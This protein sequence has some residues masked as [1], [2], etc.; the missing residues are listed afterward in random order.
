MSLF[1][2]GRDRGGGEQVLSRIRQPLKVVGMDSDHLFPL[3]QQEQ[4]T[5]LAPGAHDLQIIHSL[6]GQDG[7]L[8]EGNQLA[9]IVAIALHREGGAIATIKSDP[10]QQ[11]RAQR[12]MPVSVKN[13]MPQL[14]W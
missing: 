11:N 5:A 3:S 7:F 13:S 1:D 10:G 6:H 9:A 14:L 12:R 2:L 8:V 4:I